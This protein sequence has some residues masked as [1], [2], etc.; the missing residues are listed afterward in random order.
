MGQCWISVVDGNVGA[1]IE[2][3]DKEQVGAGKDDAE[4]A[5][6]SDCEKS[7]ISLVSFILSLQQ[8]DC[9]YVIFFHRVFKFPIL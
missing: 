4:G 2:L 8:R 6:K 1:A 5:G 3:V 7:D 9:F